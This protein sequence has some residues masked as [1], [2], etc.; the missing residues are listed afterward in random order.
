MDTVT[1]PHCHQE[2]RSDRP[3]CEHC[4]RKLAVKRLEP[5]VEPSRIKE[6]EVQLLAKDVEI[7][8]LRKVIEAITSERDTVKG[9]LAAKHPELDQAIQHLE[10]KEAQLQEAVAELEE[11]RD[12]QL[13]FIP[14]DSSKPA[15]VIRASPIPRANFDTSF[16]ENHKSLDLSATPFRIRA[17]LERDPQGWVE[18]VVHPGATI[19]IRESGQRWNRYGEGS[20][21]RLVP[22]MVVFDPKGVMNA[23]FELAT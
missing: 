11:L 7:E 18:V 23:R 3:Y 16:A 21:F 5:K 17:T 20:R 1:C 4:A 10:T 13:A 19:N 22:G 15:L 14:A 8:E 2:T 12:S 6:L 9:E